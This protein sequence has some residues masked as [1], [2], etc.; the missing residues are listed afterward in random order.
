MMML[1]NYGLSLNG[2]N[3]TFSGNGAVNDAET[4]TTTFTGVITEILPNDT[5]KIE[6][7]RDYIVGKEKSELTL[8]GIVRKADINSSNQV[9]SSQVANVKIEQKGTGPLSRSRDK[10]W[11]TTIY[12][13]LSPF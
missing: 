4:M 9:N 5:F 1:K 8:T 7:T 2:A 12:D 10:G 11:L 3:N 6:A 13:F